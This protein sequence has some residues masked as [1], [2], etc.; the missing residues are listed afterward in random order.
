V[1]LVQVVNLLLVVFFQPGHLLIGLLLER[2][3][4]LY[5]RVELVICFCVT[6]LEF[7]FLSFS[8]LLLQSVNLHDKFTISFLERHFFN[9]KLG[10]LLGQ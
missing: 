8:Y 10:L 6:H 5:V 9:V 7:I 4:T 2:T 1:L 3:L